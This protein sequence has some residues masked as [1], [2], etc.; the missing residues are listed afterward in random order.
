[1]TPLAIRNITLSVIIISI[2]IVV[3]LGAKLLK[4][5]YLPI[6]PESGERRK[7]RNQTIKRLAMMIIP[8]LLVLFTASIVYAANLDD[9]EAFAAQT[10]DINVL[11]LQF[12]SK[13][14]SLSDKTKV[15]FHCIVVYDNND[16]T[17]LYLP[18]DKIH[19]DGNTDHS[20][21]RVYPYRSNDIEGIYL[22]AET[23]EK[24]KDDLNG[25][26]PVK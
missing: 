21:V 14:K 9:Y 10:E 15:E 17:D 2:G 12:Y 19:N 5:V 25:Y 16:A 23:Y 20:Y 7:I 24:Y 1:M 3:G 6:T 11:G 18:S 22:C 8:S 26:I 13:T 4:C